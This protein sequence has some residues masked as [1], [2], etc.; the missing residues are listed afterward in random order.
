M[1]L[2]ELIRD[3]RTSIQD[4]AEPYL[5][6]FQDVARWL[7]EAESEA[8][9]RGRLIHEAD[10]EMI[11]RIELI[12]GQTA[13][14]LHRSIYEID[15][16]R[17]FRGDSDSSPERI[18]LKSHDWVNQQSRSVLECRGSPRYAIQDDNSLRLVPVPTETAAHIKIEGYRLPVRGLSMDKNSR[19]ELH[20]AHHLRLVDWAR[21]RALRLPDSDKL[22]LGES[23]EAFARFE[24]Y[25]GIRPDSDLRRITRHDVPHHVTAFWP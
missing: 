18:E 6:E 3:F 11:C 13:Y 4:V 16:I 9:I 10:D 24:Q 12:P 5:F 1:I 21:Y 17:L 14:R 2:D 7:I 20:E 8:A 22:D 23:A 25:F 15:R 19:P